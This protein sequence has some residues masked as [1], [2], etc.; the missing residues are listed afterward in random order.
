MVPV[1][2]LKGGTVVGQ[3]VVFNINDTAGTASESL[4]CFDNIKFII[5]TAE[6]GSQFDYIVNPLR[7]RASANGQIGNVI[8]TFRV[9]NIA[10]EPNETF[11]LILDPL[12]APTQREG[13]HIFYQNSI[14]VTIVD[15]DSKDI[16][17]HIP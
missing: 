16:I 5:I 11:N 4:A 6:K 13:L 1:G 14:Q 3:D 12:V 17:L 7:V 8:L 15:N 10:Q 2:Y 9:D